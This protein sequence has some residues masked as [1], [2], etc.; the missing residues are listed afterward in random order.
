M[1]HT[2]TVTRRHAPLAPRAAHLVPL[3]KLKTELNAIHVLQAT[4]WMEAANYVATPPAPLTHTM[5]KSI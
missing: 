5:I 3:T 2:T 4:L 1:V